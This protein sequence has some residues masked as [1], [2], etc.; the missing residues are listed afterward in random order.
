VK[1]SWRWLLVGLSVLFVFSSLGRTVFAQSDGRSTVHVFPQFADGR[2]SDGSYYRSAI[3]ISNPS[4]SA[5]GICTITVR[6]MFTTMEY[7][8]GSY[9][10]GGTFSVS[11]SPNSWAIYRTPG[12]G[13]FQSGYVNLSCTIPVNALVIYGFYAANGVKLS[14]AS[15]FSSPLGTLLQVL[16]DQRDGARLG[17]AVI[18]DNDLS[19]NVAVVAG[20]R[21]GQVVGSASIT[22]Q[23]RSQFVGFIDQILPS[24]PSD[25]VGQIL[26]SSSGPQLAM[27]GL[28]FTGAAFTTISSTL[29]SSSVPV[30][31][32]P[33]LTGISPTTGTQ[34]AAVPVTITGTNFVAGATNISISGSGVTIGN[35]SVSGPSSLTAVFTI[36]SSASTGNRTVTASTTAGASNA[37]NFS[38]N[39]P[40]SKPFNQLQT[41]RLLGTWRFTYTIISIF[42]DTFALNDVEPSTTTAGQWNIFGHD[43]FNNTVIAGYTP[44]LGRFTLLD[45][46]TIIDEFFVFDLTGTDIASGCYYQL[47]KGATALGTCYAMTGIRTSTNA[48]TSI[49][50]N[51]TGRGASTE[52]Q[53]LSEAR[54]TEQPNNMGAMDAAAAVESR[55]LDINTRNK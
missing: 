23:A 5:S 33:T 1:D 42:T 3:H 4:S 47:S 34:G 8:D 11:V 40:V 2:F 36:S 18:N 25:H 9:V 30:N 38:I 52:E 53:R 21:S 10:S 28:R 54:Q 43:Q 29:R 31:P 26:L 27:I 51:E 32:V 12:T 13:S 45:Q 55:R 7:L 22:I 19:A 49:T 44:S 39:A 48:I 24:I 16:S 50:E 17:I 37:V 35:V 46:G 15:V 6:G 14:E 41:E 20:N